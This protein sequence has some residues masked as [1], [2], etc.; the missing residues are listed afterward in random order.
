MKSSL[1][2]IIIFIF[3]SLS[4]CQFVIKTLCIKSVREELGLTVEEEL[5]DKYYDY[6][7]CEAKWNS[8]GYSDEKAYKECKEC[9]TE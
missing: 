5:P 6:C 3:F 4:S 7:N 1:K 9:L 2:F 8:D